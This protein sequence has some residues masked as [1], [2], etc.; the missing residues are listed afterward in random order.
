M[1]YGAYAVL[2][3]DAEMQI[4][5]IAA[6]SQW[7]WATT[8]GQ[9]LEHCPAEAS[10]VHHDLEG[11]Q[12]ITPLIVE[13]YDTYYD[14][15]HDRCNRPTAQF[16]DT[17]YSGDEDWTA[18]YDCEDVSVEAF[19]QQKTYPIKINHQSAILL[20]ILLLFIIRKPTIILT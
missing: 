12:A 9:P 17:A 3:C 15:V 5:G 7:V 20:L 10:T 8:W 6:M 2:W 14:I 13:P 11:W 4:T 19:F 1:I 16:Q 18:L